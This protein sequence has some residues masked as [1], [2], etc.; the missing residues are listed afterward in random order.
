MEIGGE[1]SAVVGNTPLVSLT[2]LGE[3]AGGA[4]V[5]VKLE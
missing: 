5:C 4:Q 3:R 1:A 2:R